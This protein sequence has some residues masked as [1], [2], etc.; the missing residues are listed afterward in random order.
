[1]RYRSEGGCEFVSTANRIVMLGPFKIGAIAIETSVIEIRR[2]MVD[3]MGRMIASSFF[4][5]VDT[6]AFHS[7][8]DDGSATCDLISWTLYIGSPG[9]EL[10]IRIVCPSLEAGLAMKDAVV[11]FIG[12][13]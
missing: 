1:M 2:C 10:D 6:V 3:G 13:R 11:S 9:N 12:S 4:D 8:D 5:G 7:F